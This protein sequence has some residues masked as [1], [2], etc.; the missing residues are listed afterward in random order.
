[1]HLVSL[2][3]LS[4]MKRNEEIFSMRHWTNKNKIDHTTVTQC[5]GYFIE[6]TL[7]SRLAEIN[8]LQ[9]K[10]MILH[11]L[12]WLS[13]VILKL[14]D[15]LARDKHR[16][17]DRNNKFKMQCISNTKRDSLPSFKIVEIRW[18][19]EGS[20]FPILALPCKIKE[21]QYINVIAFKR[22]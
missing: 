15:T 8:I 17:I 10:R 18:Y 5:F 6:Q 3:S 16:L 11:W 1:M 21:H 9:I 19:V 14:P 4:P 13:I 20:W 7:N 12:H 22:F 2:L